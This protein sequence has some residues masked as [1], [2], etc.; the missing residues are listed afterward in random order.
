M[1]RVVSR[2]CGLETSGKRRELSKMKVVIR[3]SEIVVMMEAGD[4][5]V[6]VEIDGAE[7]LRWWLGLRPGMLRLSASHGAGTADGNR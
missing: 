3:S 1:P 2:C 5:V 6:A 7:R 4:G